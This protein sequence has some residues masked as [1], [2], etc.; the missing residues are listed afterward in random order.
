MELGGIVIVVVDDPQDA[1]M[2]N[3]SGWLS[4]WLWHRGLLP[5]A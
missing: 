3:D 4:F 2:E 1:A 5:E